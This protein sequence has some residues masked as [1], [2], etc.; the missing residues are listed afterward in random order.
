LVRDFIRIQ[1]WKEN[2]DYMLLLPAKD[3]AK[4]GGS[5]VRVSAG[6]NLIG[7]YAK[8]LV[9]FDVRH[10]SLFASTFVGVS[11][12]NP[13]EIQRVAKTNRSLSPFQHFF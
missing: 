4:I 9:I 8:F 7:E 11:Q 10:A 3:I 12:I 13:E 5:Y 2:L 6:S 1:G